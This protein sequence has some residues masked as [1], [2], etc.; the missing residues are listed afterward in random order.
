MSIISLAIDLNNFVALDVETTGLNKYNDQ[1]IEISAVKFSDGIPVK[2]FTKLINPNRNIPAFITNLTGIS[3]EMVL[4]QPQ[5]EDI[6]K[7][8]EDF[9]DDLPIIGHNVMFDVD[10]I[11]KDK[12][13]IKQE[14]ICDTYYLSR[15]FYYNMNSYYLILQK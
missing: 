6:S 11:N 1:I 5:F 15:I 7:E 14:Y 9:I 4:N 12:E 13:V 3:N 10:F 2:E 8:L